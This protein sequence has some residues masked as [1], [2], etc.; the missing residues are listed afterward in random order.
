M[1]STELQEGN[2]PAAFCQWGGCIGEIMLPGC[3]GCFAQNAL[4]FAKSS[5]R[6][7]QTVW[8]SLLTFL[9]AFTIILITKHFRMADAAEHNQWSPARAQPECAMFF[10]SKLRE[11]PV[12][13]QL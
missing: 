1:E 11:N 12:F 9:V 13:S 4:E 5:R 8:G 6:I 10:V 3:A 2:H 7:N